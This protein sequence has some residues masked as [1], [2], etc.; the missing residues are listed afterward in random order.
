M[1]DKKAYWFRK[2]RG[3]GKG[4]SKME[5]AWWRRRRGERREEKRIG[6]GKWGVGGG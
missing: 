3:G 1:K 6:F 2:W 5:V 4:V